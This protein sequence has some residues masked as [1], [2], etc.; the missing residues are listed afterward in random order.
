MHEHFNAVTAWLLD[1]GNAHP[2]LRAV[3]QELA[4]R[5]RDVGLAVDRMN[6][7]VFALHPEMAGYAVLWDS[8]MEQAIEEGDIVVSGGFYYWKR[9]I[10]DHITGGKQTFHF[11]G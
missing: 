3:T 7:G 11:G 6:L 4:Q 10:H 5:L 2:R 9:D 1:A 8:S